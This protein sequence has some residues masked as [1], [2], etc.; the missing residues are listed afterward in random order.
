VAAIVT[1]RVLKTVQHD[2]DVPPARGLP[3]VG[4]TDAVGVGP[5]AAG[6]PGGRG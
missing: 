1:Y 6:R 4:P 2:D 3:A 5:A